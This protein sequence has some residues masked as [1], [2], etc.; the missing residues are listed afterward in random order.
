MLSDDDAAGGMPVLEAAVDGFSV[1]AAA[2]PESGVRLCMSA[3]LAVDSHSRDKLGW[4]PLL[5]PWKF[6]VGATVQTSPAVI[7]QSSICTGATNEAGSGCCIFAGSC[8]W[9]RLLY[10]CWQLLPEPSAT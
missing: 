5:E 7:N 8:G 3:L 9:Q 10:L 4:E 6:E 1:E 2:A